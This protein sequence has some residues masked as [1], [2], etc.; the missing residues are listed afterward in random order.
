MFITGS[1]VHDNKYNRTGVVDSMEEHG[2]GILYRIQF[3]NGKWGSYY[4]TTM[5]TRFSPVDM[6]QNEMEYLDD[7]NV[8]Y[9][10][11][12]TREKIV[13]RETWEF[14]NLIG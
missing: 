6:T 14:Y 4:E 11:F 3:E 13:D 9:I 7:S 8:L 10:N 12:K 1:R 5:E 2:R